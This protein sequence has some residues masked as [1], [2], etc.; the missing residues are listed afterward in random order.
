MAGRTVAHAM[1]GTLC[2]AVVR[3]PRATPVHQELIVQTPV[4]H[5]ALPV[6]QALTIHPPQAHHAIPVRQARTTLPPAA[7]LR[8]IVIPVQ[9]AP[10][11]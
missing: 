10:T 6:P 9:Q 4:R 5:L 11:V 2:R 8:Q 7:N 1:Q 3:I